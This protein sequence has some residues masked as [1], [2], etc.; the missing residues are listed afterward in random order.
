MA[1][2]TA[3]LG[4]SQVRVISPFGGPS[5][6]E[7]APCPLCSSEPTVRRGPRTRLPTDSCRLLTVHQRA[8]T[9]ITNTFAR[10]YFENLVISGET[11]QAKNGR[12]ADR[13]VQ[14]ARACFPVPEQNRA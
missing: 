10:T 14:R 3:D 12:Q 9:T 4:K 6:R 1:V 11:G 2:N 8:S 5:S 13:N 7:A